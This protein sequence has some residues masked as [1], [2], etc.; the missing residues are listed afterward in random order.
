MGF[1]EK[2]CDWNKPL[3]PGPLEIGFDYYFGMPTVNSGP[4]YVY[5]ENH[6]VVGYDPKD[7]FRKG[8]PNT[9]KWPE[10]SMGNIAGAKKAHLLYRDEY[11]GTTFAEKA[12][13][14]IKKHKSENADQPFFMY[15]AT[16]NIHHPFTPHPQFQ[17]T[18]QCGIYGD[19]IHELD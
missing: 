15:L 8:K 19:F 10:K 1:G 18:S 4:P 7:P 14:W 17:G 5:V 6:E 9:Q 16:T 12:V 2:K 3:K 11:V 13:G